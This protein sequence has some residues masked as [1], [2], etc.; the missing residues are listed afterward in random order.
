M[1][2]SVFVWEGKTRQGAVQ[3]GELAANSKEEVIALLRKQNI[4]P[5]NVTAKPKE[6][7]L[8]MQFG[9]PKITDKDVVIFTRQLA[10]MID[11]GL[12]LVQ[13]LDILGTQTENKSLAKIVG[14]VRSDVESGATFADALKK[15][16]KVFDNLYVNMVAAGE[17]GGIL[18]TILQRL[19]AYMEKFAKIKSQIKSAMIYPS[20]ILFVAVAVVALLL[21]VVVPMLANMFASSGQA[22]PLP[23]RIVIAFSNFLKGW[24]GLIVLV[25]IIGFFVGIKQFRKTENGLRITDGIALKIPV[26]G[27]LIQRVSVAKFTRTLGTLMT[28]G[29]PILEGLLIVSRTAGNKVVEEAIMQTRQSVSE[30]KTLAEPLGR[31][32]VFPQMVVQMIAVGEATGALDN[33][34]NKIADFYD[35]EVDA[36]VATLT[37]MLEP[38]LMI[39]LGVTVGFVII[40]MYM[41]IFQMGSTVGG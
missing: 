37:S 29:V 5:I 38:M 4:L 33:M 16:P 13:C 10:T 31:A 39:F 14:Q 6:L 19:A 15:H 34:L 23:T 9:S 41:P 8:S 27:S 25:V 22:L 36:A 28:S 35:D 32:K 12:P 20:V 30:G 26:A 1:A 11:A 24:G 7:K 18:D 40:A 3:K 2:A 21:V 17:A